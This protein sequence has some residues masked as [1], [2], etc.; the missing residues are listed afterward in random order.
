MS[1]ETNL[2]QIVRKISALGV[3]A[4][5]LNGTL[6]SA[7]AQSIQVDPSAP[8]TPSAKASLQG[9]PYIP[10]GANFKIYAQQ[11]IDAAHPFGNSAFSPQVNTNFEFTPSIGVSYDTGK[12]TPTDFGIGLY[13]PAKGMITSTGLQI[14]YNHLVD[15]ASV[16]ITLEDFDIDTKATFFNNKKVEPSIILFGPGGTVY[17]SASPIDIFPNLV[18]NMSGSA[19]GKGS[20]DMWDLNFGALLSTLHLSDAPISGFLLY[21]DTTNGEKPNSDPYLLVSVGNGVPPVP[22]PTTIALLAAS[23]SLLFVRRRR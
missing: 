22:E 10:A 8:V 20:T 5:A 17:A 9:N 12:A 19:G 2:R 16:T 21:A 3:A 1:Y 13:S 4:L 23:L 7:N 14:V 6:A 15:A 18:P 11:G